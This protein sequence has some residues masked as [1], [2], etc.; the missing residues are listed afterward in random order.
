[1]GIS[2]E[3]TMSAPGLIDASGCSADALQIPGGGTSGQEC[4]RCVFLIYDYEI[5]IHT[6][7][8]DIYIYSYNIYIYT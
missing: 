6:Y 2:S 5:L 7:S 3:A 1:M 8:D 4:M